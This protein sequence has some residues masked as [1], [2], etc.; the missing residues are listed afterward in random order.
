[1][2]HDSMLELIKLLPQHMSVLSLHTM[3]REEPL[4]SVGKEI[5][6]L[7]LHEFIIK[8]SP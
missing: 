2:G 1:M 8:D 5:F 6:A 7:A 4:V 3:T